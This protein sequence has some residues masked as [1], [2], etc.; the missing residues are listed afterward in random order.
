MKKYL[1]WL[2]VFFCGSKAVAHP[3]PSSVVGLS[4]LENAIHGEAKIPLLELGN[5]VGDQRLANLYD[6]FFT[7]YF[8]NHIKAVSADKK[9]ATK[10][11][12]IN[13][14]NDKDPF[15]GIYKEIVVDFTLTPPDSRYL[16][17]FTFQYD[18]VIHQVVTHSALVYVSQD[19]SNGIQNENE[20]Q[21]VGII[22]MDVPTEK[23]FP[24][25]VNLEAGSW[26]K[27]FSS[28]LSLGMQHI[29]EGTDHLLFLIVLLLPAMLL[30]NNGQ[31]AGFGG[32]RYS[33]KRLLKVVTAFTIGHS[34]T[35]LA[36]S[37]GWLRLPGQPVEI[38][39]AV[40]ILVSAIHAIHPLFPG[41][42]MYVAAGFGVIHGLAFATVLSNL[43]LNEGRLALSIL[44][45]NLGIEVMQLFVIAIV[46]P[47]L[48]LLSKTS[49]YKWVRISGAALA[50][51]AAM[52]WIV[53]RST[54]MPNA[55]T[56][57]VQAAT[58][59]SVW[60]IAA[61]AIAAVLVYMLTQLKR[62]ELHLNT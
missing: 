47:W 38:L 49:V 10:I 13:I 60:D 55:V 56:G 61:L 48:M 54:G 58:A 59:Y 39:I 33:I 4:V 42:E 34:T 26:W 20:A 53:E 50:G 11:T 18:A 31:W 14:I 36:G 46:V 25:Q 5:A 44:G 57:I 3:M 12:G 27:G 9:W 22:K 41:K 19:W 2:L 45:F 52:G 7:T 62:R 35:L 29:K 23:I 17:S 8:T 43:H 40:S 37:L 32:V 24:L 6:P 15:V 1:L 51:I 21:Q 30:N 28:M 16:R